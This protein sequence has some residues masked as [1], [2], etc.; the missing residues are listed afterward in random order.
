M[1]RLGIH[2]TALVACGAI[3]YNG[4]SY[5]WPTPA[6]QAMRGAPIPVNGWDKFRVRVS[7]TTT[8]TLADA[9]DSGV[10]SSVVPKLWPPAEARRHLRPGAD[11]RRLGVALQPG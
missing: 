1:P 8:M 4:S 2:E 5:D 7:G 6:A 3:F 10:I 9:Y 11:P